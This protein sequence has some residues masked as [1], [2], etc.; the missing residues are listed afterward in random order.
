M[1]EFYDVPLS[2]YPEGNEQLIKLW[3]SWY[4]L[5]RCGPIHALHATIES[6]EN[7]KGVLTITFKSL[8]TEQMMKWAIGAWEECNEIQVDFQYLETVQHIVKIEAPR[9]SSV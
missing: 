6:L 3:M 7:H 1:I 5:N 4:A 2:G 9:G 8:P